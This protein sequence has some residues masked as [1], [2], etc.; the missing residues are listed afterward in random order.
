LAFQLELFFFESLYRAP[1]LL[2]SCSFIHE[3]SS[4]VPSV[5]PWIRETSNL[6]GRIWSYKKECQNKVHV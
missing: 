3:R 1:N 5:D 4:L 2:S 6:D